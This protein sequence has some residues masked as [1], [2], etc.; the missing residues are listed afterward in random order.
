MAPVVRYAPSPTGLLR[1]SGES[2]FDFALR[3]SKLHQSYF[4]ELFSPN[5][6][7]QAEF[8]AEAAESLERQRR[9]EAADVIQFDEYLARYFAS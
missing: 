7:R 6:S 8:A 4:R 1:T 2:F 9:A 3:M 5:L